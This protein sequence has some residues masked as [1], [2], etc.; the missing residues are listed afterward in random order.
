MGTIVLCTAIY[1]EQQKTSK[2]TSTNGRKRFWGSRYENIPPPDIG[3]G[4]GL[5]IMLWDIANLL[6]GINPVKILVVPYHARNVHVQCK[7]RYSLS[8]GLN[9]GEL[10]IVGLQPPPARLYV[11]EIL[12]I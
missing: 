4:Q 11:P 6:A 7:R 10:H 1:T 8:T 2:E 3:S 9:T 12:Q 5:E